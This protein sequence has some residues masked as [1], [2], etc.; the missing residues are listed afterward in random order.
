MGPGEW[1]VGTETGGE[2]GP[3]VGEERRRG[4]RESSS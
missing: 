1:S 2:R 3:S 4:L